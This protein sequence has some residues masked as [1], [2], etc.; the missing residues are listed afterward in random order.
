MIVPDYSV[1]QM[2]LPSG[3][4]ARLSCENEK[5]SIVVSDRNRSVTITP[6]QLGAFKKIEP[7]YFAVY[8]EISG[9]SFDN[10]GIQVGTECKHQRGGVQC[11]GGISVRNGV[12]QD[13]RVLKREFR[14]G[15][16]N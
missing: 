8:S 6:E 15:P 7:W 16:D 11:I 2:Q 9:F 3:V 13:F 4:T 5:C 1:H 10:F 12:P 14:D